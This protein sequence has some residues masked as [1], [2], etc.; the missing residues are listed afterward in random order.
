MPA[1]VATI[2][3]TIVTMA[4]VDIFAMVRNGCNSA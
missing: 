4:I 1:D 3:V 2:A